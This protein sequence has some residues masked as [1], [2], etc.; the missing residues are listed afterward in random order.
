LFLL[1]ED[2]NYLKFGEAFGISTFIHL[3]DQKTLFN[4]IHALLY[5]NLV[6]SS[7]FVI[8]MEFFWQKKIIFIWQK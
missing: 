5:P 7:T 8:E 6:T 4:H 1:F 3:L 2:G